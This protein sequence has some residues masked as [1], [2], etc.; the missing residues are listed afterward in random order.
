MSKCIVC[1]KE[2]EH[3]I[4][5][6]VGSNGKGKKRYLCRECN[7]EKFKRIRRKKSNLESIARAS[8]RA[9]E[10]HRE[11]WLARAKARY[12]VKIGKLTK[13]A[14]CEECKE[15]KPLQGHHED[16]TKPLEVI[17]L[18]TG[19]HADADRKLEALGRL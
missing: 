3:L 11:K 12:A 6:G 16:Y 9:Y 2:S 19:C 10:K 14:E 5:G 13:P 8:R 15:V 4:L 18:C 7:T 17:W 1:K